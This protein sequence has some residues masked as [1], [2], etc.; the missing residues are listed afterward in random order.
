MYR[1]EYVYVSVGGS[2]EARASEVLFAAF[3]FSFWSSL[4]GTIPSFVSELCPVSFIFFFNKKEREKKPQ[5]LMKA[6]SAPQAEPSFL[7]VI[8]SAIGE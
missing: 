6:H 5:S 8:G 3:L 7:C 2:T 1:H 4:K